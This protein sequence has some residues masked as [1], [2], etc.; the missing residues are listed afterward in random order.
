[1]LDIH[2]HLL[3]G[4]DDGPDDLEESLE[5]AR[6]AVQDGITS[7]VATPHYDAGVNVV[8]SQEV[9]RAVDGMNSAL[10]AEGIPLSVFPGMELRAELSIP[11]LYSQ[12][13]VLGLCGQRKYILMDFHPVS[14]PLY[15]EKVVFQIM[16]TGTQV[17]IAHPERN[18]SIVRQP[19][20]LY[21]MLQRGVLLQLDAESLTGNFGSEVQ[22]TAELFLRLGW[23]SFIATDAHSVKHRPPVL[24]Y[25]L[26]AAAKIIGYEPARELVL[27]NPEKVI[28]GLRMEGAEIVPY[29][30]QKGM[31]RRLC[32]W[33]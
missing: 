21:P 2:C 9:L 10:K 33:L 14:L 27:D 11:G 5:M 24:S 17:I 8:S 32:P 25:A 6:L 28:K 7:V 22:R 3:P 30:T 19:E 18:R 16:L 26:K 12:N 20:V 1:M 15:L 29:K 13:E 23:V 4:L 31:L